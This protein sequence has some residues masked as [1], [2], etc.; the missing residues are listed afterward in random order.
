[1]KNL[2]AKCP[3]CNEE[4]Q[5]TYVGEQERVNKDPIEIYNCIKCGSTRSL[6]DIMEYNKD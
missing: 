2:E 6:L 4:T 1:M 5:F 3:M